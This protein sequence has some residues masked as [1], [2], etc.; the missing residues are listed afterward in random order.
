MFLF[1]KKRFVSSA[2]IMVSYILDTLHKLF[3]YIMKR[4]AP[5]ID[6]WSTLQIIS[7]LDVFIAPICMNRFLFER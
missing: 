1:E 2:N 6:P 7:R 3:T 4:R 5:K